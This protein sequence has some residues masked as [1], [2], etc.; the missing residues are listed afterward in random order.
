MD[1]R[2]PS[3]AMAHL[4][5]GIARQRLEQLTIQF[6]FP[7]HCAT[8]FQV[9]I[10]SES[11]Q[12][13]QRDRLVVHDPHLHVRS[14]RDDLFPYLIGRIVVGRAVVIGGIVTQ[15]KSHNSSADRIVTQLNGA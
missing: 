6:S 5:G 13:V 7:G 3:D 9:G 1:L 12:Y 4:G 14:R 15:T 2:V 8:H 11:V 10:S